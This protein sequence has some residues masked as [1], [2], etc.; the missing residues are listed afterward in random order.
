MKLLSFTTIVLI[1]FGLGLYP[2]DLGAQQ[3]DL[4]RLKRSLSLMGE[5]D[6]GK[7]NLAT[8]SDSLIKHYSHVS[9]ELQVI[10]EELTG[11]YRQII[12]LHAAQCRALINKRHALEEA[13]SILPEGKD[14]LLDV[15]YFRYHLIR[16]IHRL[17]HGI[18]IFEKIP[19]LEAMKPEIAA[20]I[21]LS[22]FTGTYGDDKRNEAYRKD[23]GP[24][25]FTTAEPPL[26]YSVLS[27][28]AYCYYEMKLYEDAATI[29]R[30]DLFSGFNS[31]DYT[32]PGLNPL[33]TSYSSTL[34]DLMAEAEMKSGDV[35]GAFIA[36]TYYVI[37][38]R[39]RSRWENVLEKAVTILEHGNEQGEKAGTPTVEGIRRIIK[40]Y[41]AVGLE[42][43]A[44]EVLTNYPIL[45]E[46]DSLLAAYS[47]KWSSHISH[48]ITYWPVAD[49]CYFM[50]RVID[51]S[52]ADSVP[53][54][55]D[56]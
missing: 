48:V 39:Y 44:R 51:S 7:S 36:L 27:D 45:P 3:P 21:P 46:N 28:I 34:F 16:E 5:I 43:R 12:L 37:T 14:V 15:T 31:P 25:F 26:Y 8:P 49:S 55:V 24:T 47:Q 4:E 17:K 11:T 52:Y 35:E 6:L 33:L 1:L 30:E 50:G 19:A 23:T 13:L 32:L 42:A 41:C 2:E 9:S 40:L 22:Y 54:F 18:K 56:R 20:R 29:Y 38:A 10:A 53:T